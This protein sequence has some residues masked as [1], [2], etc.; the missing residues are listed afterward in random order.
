MEASSLPI[1]TAN[2]FSGTFVLESVVVGRRS[3]RMS[4]IIARG[5]LEINVLVQ[6][7]PR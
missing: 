5:A 3:K 4:V 7:A 2:N 1:R 6:V